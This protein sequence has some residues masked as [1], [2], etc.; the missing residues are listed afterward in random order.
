MFIV[1]IE[2]KEL[3]FKIQDFY[4][5]FAHKTNSHSYEK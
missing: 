3:I 5:L 2:V 4:L 1:V